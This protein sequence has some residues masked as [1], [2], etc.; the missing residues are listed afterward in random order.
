[1]AF[2]KNVNFLVVFAAFLLFA[3][4]SSRDKGKRLLFN[5]SFNYFP[6]IYYIQRKGTTIHAHFILYMNIVQ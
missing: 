6:V 2:H 5:V 1:M 4:V 3:N